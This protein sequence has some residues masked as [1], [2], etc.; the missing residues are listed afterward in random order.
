MNRTPYH[1]S[2]VISNSVWNKNQSLQ[3][4]ADTTRRK[5]EKLHVVRFG[6]NVGTI[7]TPKTNT[8]V[9]FLKSVF[10]SV[11]DTVAERI[12]RAEGSPSRKEL[13]VHSE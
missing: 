13:S 5:Q 7:S 10:S 9:F 2:Y 6:S 12:C 3:A 8:K 11:R 4:K 1:A